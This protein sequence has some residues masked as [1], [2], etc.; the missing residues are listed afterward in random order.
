MQKNPFLVDF[1]HLF[2]IALQDKNIQNLIAEI[3]EVIL[4]G[5][6]PR[7]DNLLKSLFQE[8]TLYY[9]FIKKITTS[10]F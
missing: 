1:S 10:I 2:S 8:K 9:S 4:Y 5:N 6:N 7:V 3:E